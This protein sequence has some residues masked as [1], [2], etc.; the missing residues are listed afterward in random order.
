MRVSVH[1][2]AQYT[3]S[4]LLHVNHSPRRP[5]EPPMREKTP[6]MVRTQSSEESTA[7]QIPPRTSMMPAHT[8]STL[9]VRR[10]RS[11][12][13]VGDAVAITEA[14]AGSPGGPWLHTHR[15]HLAYALSRGEC[16]PIERL[17]LHGSASGGRLV[18]RNCVV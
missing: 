6:A 9:V 13:A 15:K 11:L 3:R 2:I 12:V 8:C 16:L 4:P 17:D 1:A 7:T 5:A 18:R 10:M 14:A